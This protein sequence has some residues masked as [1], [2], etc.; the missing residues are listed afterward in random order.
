MV[1]LVL[2]LGKF[3]GSA[4]IVVELTKFKLHFLTTQLANLV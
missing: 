3:L 4:M 2:F 1:V